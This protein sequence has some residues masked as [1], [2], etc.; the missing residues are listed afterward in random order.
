M[1]IE[2]PDR[3]PG[4]G[5]ALRPMREEDAAAYAEAYAQDPD[6]GRLLG[7]ESDPDERWIRHRIARQRHLAGQ[8]E[9]VELAIV[10]PSEDAFLGSVILH[11]FAWQHRRC[12]VG[13]WLVAASRRRGLGT[14]AVGLAIGWAFREL[15][16][17]RVEM[18]T[19]V[20]N[21]AAAA[22]GRRLGFV[23]EGLMR[24]RNVERGERVDIVWFGLLRE[25]WEKVALPGLE[26]GRDRL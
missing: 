18:T 13:F 19:T 24:A 26:P 2:L 20:D 21:G 6:L 25:D 22:L 23:R 5:V 15:E 9:G 7:V 10:L 3:L 12:E 16:L 8:G 17:L 1:R 14:R 11:S 4:E